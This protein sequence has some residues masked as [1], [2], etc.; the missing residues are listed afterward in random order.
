MHPAKGI[1]FGT[2]DGLHDGHKHFL[3]LAAAKC[4][5]L[6]VVV[7]P[8]ETVSALKGQKPRLVLSER[9]ATVKEFMPGAR[10]VAGDVVNGSWKILQNESPDVAILG[11]DQDDLA[12]ELEAQGLRLLSLPAHEPEKFKSSILNGREPSGEEQR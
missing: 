1:V 8:D 6:V 11:Y 7:A 2:F 12:R 10:V 5:T 4:G 9:M 3:R